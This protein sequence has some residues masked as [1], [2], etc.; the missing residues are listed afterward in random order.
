M[1]ALRCPD[2]GMAA[3]KQAHPCTIRINLIQIH[4]INSARII[5]PG[6]GNFAVFEQRKDPGR[7]SGL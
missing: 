7:G 4:P 6:K 1:V 2:H 5:P 3:K